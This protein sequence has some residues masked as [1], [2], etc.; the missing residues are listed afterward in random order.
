M[1]HYLQMDLTEL[2]PELS[3]KIVTT[4]ADHVCCYCQEIIPSGQQARVDVGKTP[5]R[6]GIRSWYYCR[7][8][9][10]GFWEADDY[11]DAE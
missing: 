1:K 4:R 6:D 7:E 2:W 3:R 9:L 10:E 5:D 8:C 11:G